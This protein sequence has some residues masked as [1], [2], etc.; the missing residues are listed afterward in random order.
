MLQENDVDINSMKTLK[1]QFQ[2]FD[3]EST[4]LYSIFI[5]TLSYLVI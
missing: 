3:Q 2:V 4:S 5:P 1:S